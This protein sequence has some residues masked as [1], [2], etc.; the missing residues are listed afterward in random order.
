[1][2]EGSTC[3]LVL[4]LHGGMKPSPP[5]GEWQGTISGQAQFLL[6]TK[7]DET[8]AVDILYRCDPDPTSGV[9]VSSVINFVKYTEPIQ[10]KA[11]GTYF[12]EVKRRKK[13]KKKSH[14]KPKGKREK[15]KNAS[16]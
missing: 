16:Q 5:R 12:I 7:P 13:A 14:K 3:F 2:G 15:V 11:A 1:M 9:N 10:F 8:E 4:R 6:S